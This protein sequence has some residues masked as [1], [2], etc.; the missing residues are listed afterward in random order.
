MPASSHARAAET[1]LKAHASVALLV[2]ERKELNAK[3]GGFDFSALLLCDWGERWLEVEVDGEGHFKTTYDT[4]AEQ[5]QDADRRKDA[6]AYKAGRCLVRLH[7]QDRDCWSQYLNRAI[8][9]ATQPA[10]VK[11]IRYTPSYEKPVL[12]AP[13]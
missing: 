10:Q 6:A 5:Q 12:M 9:L 11:F 8:K 2:T 1:M 3:F 13:I 7:F 4:S